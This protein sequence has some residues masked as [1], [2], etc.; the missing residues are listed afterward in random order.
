[1][2]SDLTR[3]FRVIVGATLALAVLVLAVS[4]WRLLVDYLPAPLGDARHLDGHRIATRTLI[5]VGT[6]VVV[7]RAVA[8]KRGERAPIPLTLAA[9]GAVL[10]A[11][12]TFTVSRLQWDQLALWAVTAAEPRRY[13][14]FL[15]AAFDDD[16]RFVLVGNRELSSGAYA[17]ILIGHLAATVLGGAA[18]VAGTVWPRA[19]RREL[20]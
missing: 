20:R 5:A 11:I 16:V 14:G 13:D 19:A 3:W 15:S 10:L 7:L 12:T 2:R 8:W 9:V 1:M 18:V 6:A 17:W 4:T